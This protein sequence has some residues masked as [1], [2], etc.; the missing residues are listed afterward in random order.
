MGPPDAENARHWTVRDAES[1]ITHQKLL[2]EGGYGEVH[3]VSY[4]AEVLLIEDA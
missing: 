4:Y 3:Q 1:N 2:G